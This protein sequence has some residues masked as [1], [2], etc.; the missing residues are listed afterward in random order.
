MP[1]QHW[2]Q[3]RLRQETLKMVSMPPVLLLVAL[4]S[5]SLLMVQQ[6]AATAQ[7]Y[8]SLL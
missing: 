7:R 6:L 2:A 5:T 1:L 3:Q 4:I 8:Q